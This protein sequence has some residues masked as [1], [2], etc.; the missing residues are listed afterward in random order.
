V[1][2]KHEKQS[3]GP[4]AQQKKRIQDV[5]VALFSGFSP[6]TFDF[7]IIWASKIKKV[8]KVALSK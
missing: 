8:D 7:G 1:W 4:S 5:I 6:F 2:E 3:A